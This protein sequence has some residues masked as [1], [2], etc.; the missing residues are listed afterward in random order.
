MQVATLAIL[1]SC[2]A[3]NVS[4]LIST[5]HLPGQMNAFRQVLFDSRPRSRRG[6]QWRWFLCRKPC[7][8]VSSR[9]CSPCLDA[10]FRYHL[11]LL[12]GYASLKIRVGSHPTL[13]ASHQPR[14]TSPT[15][16][17]P[18][19][20]MKCLQT[21]RCRCVDDIRHHHDKPGER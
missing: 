10:W 19:T 6:L 3:L 2:N 1:I 15:S 17:Q 11:V 9:C 18:R 14:C 8:R 12:C 7:R 21:S 4:R 16:T 5:S 20:C 13:P